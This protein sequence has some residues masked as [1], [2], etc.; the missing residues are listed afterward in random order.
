MSFG[1]KENEIEMAVAKLITEKFVVPVRLLAREINP[2]LENENTW[3]ALSKLVAKVFMLE[4]FLEQPA[5]AL[6]DG[7]RL[8]KDEL[9][10]MADK[11]LKPA[12]KEIFDQ[13]KA[14]IEME[15]GIQ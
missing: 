15:N 2:A 5:E 8:N 10:K 1:F 7:K 4:L 12:F 6:I 13:M 9:L 3:I 14:V 11:L